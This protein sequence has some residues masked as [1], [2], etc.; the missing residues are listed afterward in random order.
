MNHFDYLTSIN[1]TKKDIM[2]DDLAEKDYNSFMINRGLSY[3]IDTILTANEMNT[4][5]FIDKRMQYDFHMNLVRK[6]KRWSKWNKAE[7]DKDIKVVKEY[8]NYSN[9]KARQAL[10]ILTPENI[11]DLKKRLRKGGKS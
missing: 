10:T 7:V 4:K 11:E 6:K 9:E 3:F 2:V 8:Y 1:D 5:Y